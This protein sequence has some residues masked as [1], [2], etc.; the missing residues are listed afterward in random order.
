MNGAGDD[1]VKPLFVSGSP[2]SCACANSRVLRAVYDDP[3]EVLVSFDFCSN[4]NP[5][6]YAPYIL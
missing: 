3:I 4:R 6:A 5:I 2:W 1:D